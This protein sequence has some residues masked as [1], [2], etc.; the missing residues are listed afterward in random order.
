MKKHFILHVPTL[1]ETIVF[2]NGMSLVPS[3]QAQDDLSLYYSR[4][5]KE[6]IAY[7]QSN[8]KPNYR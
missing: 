4:V 1:Q 8:I 6:D 5:Q 3:L 2:I 7:K